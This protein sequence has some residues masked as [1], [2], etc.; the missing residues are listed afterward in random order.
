MY[1]DPSVSSLSV[2]QLIDVVAT[3]QGR[4]Q[5]AATLHLCWQGETV[6]CAGAFQVGATYT[7]YG[8]QYKGIQGSSHFLQLLSGTVVVEHP[9]LTV[10]S[11]RDVKE[12]CAGIGG[13]T[14]G[15][16]SLGGT[17]WAVADNCPLACD[18]LRMQ[19]APVVQGDL[20]EPQVRQQVHLAQ[21][22]RRCLLAAG[23]PCQ[24]YSRQGLMLGFCDSRSHVLCHVLQLAWH[25]QSS[26]IV[27]ECVTE[28]Q[29]HPDARA[30]IYDFA[31]HAGFQVSEVVLELSHQWASK[32]L[33]WWATLLPASMPKFDLPNW[34]R[35]EQVWTV[36]HVIPEWPIWPHAVES[37][38]LWDPIELAAYNNSAF[39]ADTRTLAANMQAPTALHSWG[40]A[41]RACPCGCRAA[42]FSEQSLRSRG[43]RGI[44]V[45]SVPLT[46]QR[47]LHPREVGLL[48]AL[49]PSHPLPAGARAALCLVGQLS[50]PLQAIW[51]LVHIRVWAAE[52]LG[53][54]PECPA[55]AL[56]RFQQRLLHQRQ[57]SWL[58]PSLLA[59]GTI[60][61]SGEHFSRRLTVAEPV[62]VGRL[63]QAAKA[64]LAAGSFV[65]VCVGER[66][67]L[68]FAYLHPQ[69]TGP[70]YVVQIV[71]KRA[72][73][74]EDSAPDTLSEVMA[75]LSDH[76]L[77]A[78][79]AD[80][81]ASEG[82]PLPLANA[83]LG[84]R[85]YNAPTLPDSPASL[86]SS[87]VW[88]TACVPASAALLEHA[89]PPA[90]EGCSDLAIWCGLSA[91]LKLHPALPALLLPPRVADVLLGIARSGQPLPPCLA[92]AGPLCSGQALL[93]PFVD[94]GHWTL[95]VLRTSGRIVQA[96]AFDGIPGRNTDGAYT[97]AK[98]LCFLGGCDL[99][100]FSEKT[101]WNQVRPSDCGAIVLA[102]ALSLSPDC[103]CD[104]LLQTAAAFL[105][106]LPPLPSDL[107]GCGGLAP[108]QEQEL[109]N[110]LVQKGVPH[111]LVASRV[112]SAVAKVGAGALAG[113][114]QQKNAWQALKAVASR[115]GSLFKWVQADE[116]QAHIERKA[117]DRFGTEVSKP[118]QKKQKAAKRPIAAPLHVDPNQLQLAEGS[119]VAT[120]GAP[121]KQLAFNEVQAQASGICFCTTA[122]AGP[123]LS[124][125][126]NLSV[127]ALALA[128]LRVLLQQV[129]EFKVCKDTACGGKCSGFHAAVDEIVEHL[130]LD[131]WARQWV[132][133]AG[134][135]T[136]PADAELFQVFVRLPAS[137][138]PHVF[139]A[140]LDGLYIEPRAADGTGP[141]AA[142]AVVWLPGYS[143]A[144]AKH[145]LRTS[146]RAITVTRLGHKYGLRTKEAD[147]QAVF[148]LLRPQHQF[149]KVRVTARFRLHPLPHGFQRHN[150][151]QLLQQWQWVSKP[152]QP[153][154][155]D[156]VGCAWIVGA[157]SDPPAPAL[158]LGTG[159]VLVSKIK[160]VGQPRGPSK[161]VCA[162]TRTRKALLLDDDGDAFPPDPWADGSDPWSSARQAAVPA[163]SST[164]A[165]TKIAQV[166]AGLK[167]DLEDLVQRKLDAREAAGPPPG[168]SDQDKRLHVLETAVNE[169]RHQ[170]TK[171]ESWFQGFGTKVA[172]QATQLETLQSTVQEQQVELGRVRT[173]L[174]STVQ[175]AVTSL[176]GN[177][178]NQM[179]SQLAGQMEQ[180]QR[181][182][183]PFAP[184]SWVLRCLCCLSFFVLQCLSGFLG[185]ASCVAGLPLWVLSC[186]AADA[187]RLVPST[188]TRYGEADH[189]GPDVNFFISTSNPSGL[190]SKE[191]L[192]SDWGFGVHCFAETQLSAVTLPG[193]RRQFQLCAKA[194]GRQ[195]RV[196]AGAPAALRVNSQWAGTW[197]GVLQVS[198][199]PSCPYNVDWP[200][201]L[202]ESG[203]V[204]ISQHFHELLPV[205]VATVYGYPQGPTWPDALQRTEQ[206]LCSITREVVLGS[207]GFRVICGDFN[208]DHTRLHQC[209]LWRSQGWVEAQDLA[210]MI[211]GTAPQPTCKHATRRDFVWLSPEAAAYCVQVQLIEVFQEHSTLIAGFSLPCHAVVE[212]SWPLPAELPWADVDVD[213]WHLLAGHQP[214]APV[215]DSTRWF[216]AFSHAFEHSLDGH[217]SSF[218]GG[219]L[220][221]NC[222]GRGARVAPQLATPSVRPLRASRPGEDALRHDGLGAE[223]RRWFQQLRRLQSLAHA[224]RADNQAPSAV[225]YRLGLW[226]SILRARGFR[227][228]F[229]TWWTSRPVRLV[230]SPTTVPSFVPAAATARLLYE[231]FRC[232]FRKLESWHLRRRAQVLDAKYDKSLAQLYQELRDPTPEQVDTLQVRREYA[233]LATDPESAQLHVERPLDQRGNSTWAIDGV[234]VQVQSVE[235]DMCTLSSPVSTSSL[236]LE[237][238]Q[239]LSSVADIHVEFTSLWAPRWQQ[240]AAASASDWQR[241]LD[242]AS[243][244]LPRH[245]FDL[246]D[247]DPQTWKMALRRFKP[248]AARGP[249]GW[250]RADLLA[251]PAARTAELLLFLRSLELDGRPWPKQLVV[252]FVCLLCKGNGRL[253]AEGFRPIC[254]FSIIYRTWAGIR[255]RQVLAAVKH[256]VP[257]GLFGFVPGHEPAELWYSVQLEVE[258]SVLADTR[259]LG[260]STDAIKCFNNLPRLPLLALAAQL[261][262]PQRLLSPWSSFLQVC[263]RRFLVRGQ[264]SPATASTSGFP[265]GCPLSPVAMV[266]A[267]WAF[268]AYLQAFAPS[269][270][271]LSFVDNFACTAFSAAALV[272]AYNLVRCFM[273]LL[274]LQLD[275]AKTFVW[276]T[277]AKDRKALSCLGFSVLP[278][279]RE[280]GGIMSYGATVRNAALKRRCQS[281]T[282]IWKRLQRSRAPCSLKLQVL[283]GKCWAKALHGISGVPLSTAA[284]HSL[285]TAA[286]AALQI[287]PGGSSS[288]LRLSLSDPMI[289][290]PGFYQLWSCVRDVR[291]MAAKVPNFLSL[292]RSFH[293][294]YDGRTLHGPFSK[295]VQV[296]AQ[297]GW[298]V[299]EP[300]V[301][302]DHDGLAHHVLR[303]PQAL[304]RRLLEQ[305]WLR[306]VAFQHR[307]RKA[308]IDLGGIDLALLRAVQSKLTALDTARLAAIHSGAFLCSHQHSYYDLSQTGLCSCCQ[309]PDTVE[310]KVRYCPAN[311]GARGEHAWVLDLWDELPVSLTH[312]LLPS[313]N[314]QLPTLRRLLQAVVDTTGCFYA[315][316]CGDGWQFLFTDGSCHEFGHADFALAGWGVILANNGAAL[317][318]GA[319]PGLQQ[320]APRAEILAM[321]AAVRWALHTGLPCIAWTDAANV[322]DGVHLIQDTGCLPGTADLDLWERL[323]GFLGQL[324][325]RRFLVRHTPSHLD[326]SLTESPLEDWLAV[327]N[328]HADV[329]AGFANVNR[330]QVFL[331]VHQKAVQYYED[332]SCILRALRAIFFGIAALTPAGTVGQADGEGDDAEPLIPAGHATER[333]LDLEDAIPLNWVEVIRTS[334]QDLPPYFVRSLCELV[335]RLDAEAEHA[336]ELSWLELVFI[337]H[338]LDIQVFPV[339]DGLGRWSD[340]STL[341]F[342]PASQTVAV[343]L[344]LVRRALRPALRCLDLERLLVQGI[345]RLDLGVRFPL[346]GLIIGVDTSLLLKA[347]TSLGRFV[348]GRAGTR[349]MLARPI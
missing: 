228:G 61:L 73:L 197:T 184:L 153:D 315:N 170:S 16:E 92:A 182:L 306:H 34:P 125:G 139:C 6:R 189:P 219:H 185:I 264:V 160:D 282:P 259:L 206:L 68:A 311:E 326:T 72:R 243:A 211:W 239:T 130:F 146:E 331:D 47:F 100:S 275:V 273:D 123:F 294:L 248:R 155:G 76:A 347:R 147:E 85:E 30:C 156:S 161:D 198:D 231:D 336:Y 195:A 142:W 176:Q 3:A 112:Q 235:D 255:A 97:L 181:A 304:L 66:P 256:L 114:L 265:E 131:A 253:D 215:P 94:N 93:A 212:T 13:I 327:H 224:A 29:Q 333:R 168:F 122:Q 84:P 95:L 172:D 337:L 348:Q 312:H 26:G 210:H 221:A 87:C 50:S 45:P 71:A 40:N 44:G 41:L 60:L 183:R 151:V 341:A 266:F 213:A 77:V 55:D 20:A 117:Q 317:A 187:F 28:I 292:W 109:Q 35:C 166:E 291:R 14:V 127:D 113:A 254:L 272:Q 296:L 214:V 222:F 110:L 261:G 137:A 105:S 51:V 58:T 79:D 297:V 262:C 126:R 309:V 349:S 207:R 344:G 227:Y 59:G 278:A 257:E 201:G 32:R 101:I 339:C 295:L 49:P 56:Q 340:P 332:T 346:D 232:N 133:L 86:A 129:P 301:L 70:T 177:L 190:R 89:S 226:R 108:E 328:N 165:V 116:L 280:I 102:H 318:S 37:E 25:S 324:D 246:P 194:A 21:T 234:P 10:D 65:R 83:Q 325:A 154:R 2:G 18:A 163:S 281:L 240:H 158:A 138:L 104:N 330:P 237:Q 223:V 136:K 38:L 279:S 217:V 27:L 290:D 81:P 302:L 276:A 238:V 334:K 218:P 135:K 152:L 141:H 335:F 179:A 120:S 54:Q 107:W 162:S 260:L 43:L 209:E 98:S 303:A 173:D 247:I 99:D 106:A 319:V 322:A 284:V 216:S 299:L 250:A 287:R 63:M 88:P 320:T 171:F 220:P 128:P 200:P 169:M 4:D 140:S 283:P 48:N 204:M 316:G 53:G 39:G 134:G 268:H 288:L 236:E 271:A 82:L 285:R 69:P 57:D 251:M 305:A 52:H 90:A 289:A 293:S 8:V 300:P 42:A 80:C 145:A 205:T 9:A 225:D 96:Q 203:R 121:L 277:Q 208:H 64:V 119:F 36:G 229:A 11:F 252:G 33:R 249:D 22:S 307:H 24:G 241:F 298:S 111:E 15:C 186:P 180:I 78:A 124:M 149:L 17:C 23:I 313:E 323:A 7:L 175:A 244:Y 230:G 1:G 267:D 193:S 263:Q 286:T 74:G 192:Y 148:E 31:K 75:Q 242:F 199:L 233:I 345:D 270:R 338:V 329:L 269:A 174:Q 150:L 115:P 308:M 258:L 202:F 62:T 321:T 167:Q 314:P 188:A 144:Q 46:E 164:E 274:Q 143:A 132:K 157:S 12:V 310:H 159:F 67:L 103:D 19:A 191:P 196:T 343:R 342:P 178:T 91:V 5:Q 118:R 245:S